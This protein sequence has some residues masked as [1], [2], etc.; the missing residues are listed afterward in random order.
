MDPPSRAISPA[1]SPP[2]P[3]SGACLPRPARLQL[4][5]FADVQIRDARTGRAA[6]LGSLWAASPVVLVFLRRL[7][8]QMCRV[9]C[10]EY[11][12]EAAAVRAAGAEM[13]ALTFEELGKGSDAD[14]SFEAGGY[15]KGPLYCI[16]IAVYEKLFGR[17]GLFSG[18][19]GLA[20][21]SRTKLA[22][23]TSRGVTGNFRGD[24]LLLGGQF[25]VAPPG[26]VLLEKRQ[27]FFGDDLTVAEIVEGLVAEKGK[28]AAAGGE[29]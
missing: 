11:Q 16:D 23:C 3:I 28:A 12:E 1:P 19:F 17:K 20:D 27:A 9:T 26:H 15:W 10:V 14:R 25:V 8:C 2:P 18:F 29:A 4:S 22:A 13:V 5:D 6:T 24:G 7:G 21:V